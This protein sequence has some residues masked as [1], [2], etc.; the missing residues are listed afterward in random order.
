[1]F[2]RWLL[3]VVLLCLGTVAFGQ[4]ADGKL[5]IHH[6]DVGQGDG[7]VL[8]SPGGQVVLFDMGEDLRKKDCQGAIDYLDQMGVKQIDYIFVS[9][10]HFDHI[11]CIPTVLKMFPLKG[12]SYDRGEKY[13]TTFYSD[14][15]DAVSA[16]RETV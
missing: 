10:Y 16:H 15:V 7:A 4:V 14:Y 12:P 11:G 3:S 8:V 9:H 13:D 1:M 6:I 5:Q 2:K